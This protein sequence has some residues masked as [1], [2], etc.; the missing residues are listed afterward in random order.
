MTFSDSYFEHWPQSARDSATR[1]GMRVCIA[2]QITVAKNWRRPSGCRLSAV[3]TAMCLERFL[4]SDADAVLGTG[5][6]DRGITALAK[7]L[8]MTV[9]GHA[10]MH[11][12]PATLVA[13]YRG[14]QREPLDPRNESILQKLAASFGEGLS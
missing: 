7:A 9:L 2:N 3:V 4:R 8:G 11:G 6:D 1:A 10:N 5:R 12:G 14:S 13:L